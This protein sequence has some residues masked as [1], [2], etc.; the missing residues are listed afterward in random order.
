MTA[1]DDK[2]CNN[3][4]LLMLYLGQNRRR[5][6]VL[7]NSSVKRTDENLCSWLRSRSNYMPKL[8]KTLK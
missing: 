8:R 1:G 6:G 4:Q 7:R 3:V 2:K 5:K